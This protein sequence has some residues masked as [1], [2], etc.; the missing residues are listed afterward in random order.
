[1]DL[2]TAFTLASSGLC[3]FGIAKDKNNKKYNI[4]G[5]VM[6]VT[7]FISILTYFFYE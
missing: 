6:L 2:L 3:F 4:A 5:I 1:M 7:S